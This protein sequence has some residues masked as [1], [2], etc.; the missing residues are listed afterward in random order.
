MRFFI[1]PILLTLFA[2]P[3]LLAGLL[4]LAVDTQPTFDR[5]AEVTPSS[6]ERAKRILAQNDPRKLKSGAR[7][8]VTVNSGDLDLAANYLAHRYGGGARVG[9]KR[10]S[11]QIGASIRV[12]RLPVNLYLNVD[13]SLTEQSPLPRLQT[14]RVGR[15]PVPS[16]IV[17]RAIALGPRT[18][19]L[20]WEPES[21]SRIIRQVAFKEQGVA[22]TYEWLGNT[23]TSLRSIVIPSEDHERIAIYQE[24]LVSV[25]QKID[26]QKVSLVDFLVP[27]LQLARE[28]TPY[29]D[30]IG[31]TRAWRAAWLATVLRLDGAAWE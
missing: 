7:R 28:R 9:L 20:S 10:G 31:A 30:A 23:L 27:F 22:V 11:T 16:W 6:I 18:L 1:K 29:S 19:G 15:L 5:A 25:A 3:L 26:R 17:Y 21:L 14:F 8:T 13:A 2:L 4:F 24:L 12:P